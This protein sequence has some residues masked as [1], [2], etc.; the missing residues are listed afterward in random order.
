MDD[1]IDLNQTMCSLLDQSFE[2]LEREEKI[3]REEELREEVNEEIDCSQSQLKKRKA[4]EEKEEELKR[5]QNVRLQKEMERSKLEIQ[6]EEELKKEIENMLKA[7]EEERKHEVERREKAAEDRRLQLKPEVD[8]QITYN[9]SQ[10]FA[11][12]A[13]EIA[14]QAKKI[15]DQAVTNAKK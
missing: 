12:Q 11:L 6:K 8:A 7:E 5:I 14:D 13:R 10:R 15:A 2:T 4:V 3:M 1:N 9:R